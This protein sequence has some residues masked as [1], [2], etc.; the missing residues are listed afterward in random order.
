MKPA[1]KKVFWLAL[2]FLQA[3]AL[4]ASPLKNPKRMVQS[5][6]VDLKPLF[7]WWTTHAGER[8]LRSWVQITGK[9]VGTNGWGW[10][11]EAHV[12][13]ADTASEDGGKRTRPAEGKIVLKNP[14]VAE[15][16]EF[17]QSHAQ[18]DS[19]TERVKAL[20]TQLE[21]STEK[22]K[23][24]N[25]RD[26]ALRQRHSRSR[27]LEQDLKKWRAVEKKD[28]EQLQVANKQL[29]ELK[30]KFS[31]PSGSAYNLDCFALETS[32]RN[33]GMDVYDHGAP[34]F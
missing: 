33:A 14:P 29:D 5:Q 15:M 21:T 3:G 34:T 10:I 26:N 11:V 12:T 7:T 22:V 4:S 18:M 32:E 9:V 25:A 20:S 19:M 1:L 17:V 31:G 28:K 6:T 2:C 13:A 30:K 23:E 8:P 27:P 16:T 24:L